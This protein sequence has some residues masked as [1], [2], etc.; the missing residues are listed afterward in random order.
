MYNGTWQ[1]AIIKSKLRQD[2]RLGKS[3][4]ETDTLHA[5][6][7][8]ATLFP[9]LASVAA[10]VYTVPFVYIY[11]SPALFSI[12]SFAE[13]IDRIS[14]VCTRYIY[15]RLNFFLFFLP[16]SVSRWHLSI[17]SYKHKQRPLRKHRD[18]YDYMLYLCNNGFSHRKNVNYTEF[19]I[20]ARARAR[21]FTDRSCQIIANLFSVLRVLFFFYSKS[22]LV[23][24]ISF[25]RS[26]LNQRLSGEKK[27]PR[28]NEYRLASQAR[29]RAHL[30]SENSHRC[31]ELALIL[32]FSQSQVSERNRKWVSIR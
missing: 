15:M 23:N 17:R 9:W 21:V 27:N 12:F 29:A 13:L 25:S 4:R 6:V 30:K 26:L 3:W 8:I 5:G 11:F 10:I 28:A 14:L 31:N 22:Y 32:T 20:D 2:T 7:Y 24:V 19:L 18:P 1:R 16:R